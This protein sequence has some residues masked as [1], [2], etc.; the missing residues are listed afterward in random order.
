V[1]LGAL[2]EVVNRVG[3]FFYGS[4]LGVFVLAVGTRAGAN[5]ALAGLVTG[6]ITVALV[7]FTTN[8]AYLWQNVIG[9]LVVVIVGVAVGR[10]F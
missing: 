6:M 10:K 7:G 8:V 3:S 2:I 9:T 4:L 1:N 5:G